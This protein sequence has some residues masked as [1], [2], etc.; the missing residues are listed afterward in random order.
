M[1]I[2]SLIRMTVRTARCNSC[3]HKYLRRGGAARR[4]V[5]PLI[6]TTYGETLPMGIILDYFDKIQRI[7][8]NS[9]QLLRLG[10]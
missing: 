1:R 7:P 6:P 2:M 9:S 8:V 10:I 5:T 3:A 4:G